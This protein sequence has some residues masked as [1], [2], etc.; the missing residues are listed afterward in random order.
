MQVLAIPGRVF[1]WL[2]KVGVGEEKA[3]SKTIVRTECVF[4]LA[5]AGA[6]LYRNDDRA[7]G[8]SRSWGEAKYLDGKGFE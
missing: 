3:E 6:D 8:G 1:L 4:I 7:D 5:Q 2:C